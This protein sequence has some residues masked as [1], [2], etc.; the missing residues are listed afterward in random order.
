MRRI[1]GRKDAHE[2]LPM[3]MPNRHTFPISTYSLGIF[4]ETN[5]ANYGNESRPD[6]VFDWQN[7]WRKYV[8][9]YAHRNAY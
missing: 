6:V 5:K 1:R 7:M 2:N 8:L 4:L 9:I 3:T